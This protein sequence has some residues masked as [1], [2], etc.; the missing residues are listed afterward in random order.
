MSFQ[1][2]PELEKEFLKEE[3]YDAFIVDEKGTPIGHHENFLE[4]IENKRITKELDE[5]AIQLGWNY[6]AHMIV[7]KDSIEPELKTAIRII[8]DLKGLPEII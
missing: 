3:G 2:L 8:L 5:L 4:W 7:N 1:R 6:A